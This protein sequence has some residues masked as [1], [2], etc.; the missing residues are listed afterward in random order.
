MRIERIAIDALEVEEVVF[1]APISSAT[2]AASTF[3]QTPMEASIDDARNAATYRLAES[4]RATL[5]P[6][7][8]PFARSDL[9]P[10]EWRSD[11][12]HR[13]TADVQSGG[14]LQ[15]NRSDRRRLDRRR[16]GD[17]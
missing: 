15:R 13:I 4:D 9:Y 6:A 10:I 5:I 11:E 2:H 14:G 12:L 8:A 17:E 3:G 7:V 1:N 16:H